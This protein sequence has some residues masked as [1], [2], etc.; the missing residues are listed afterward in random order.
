VETRN[1]GSSAIEA[2]LDYRPDVI[3]LDI[4]MPGMSGYEVARQL[5]SDAA[6]PDDLLLVALTGYGQ[7]EDRRQALAA[8]FDV[9][10]VKPVDVHI[11]AQFFR[12]PPAASRPPLPADA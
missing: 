3:F 9:H 2:A 11:L 8:G 6:I 10:M 4:A 7:E 5:R 1:D 12:N